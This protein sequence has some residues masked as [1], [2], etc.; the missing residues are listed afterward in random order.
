M[1]DIASD[2]Q[3]LSSEHKNITNLRELAERLKLYVTFRTFANEKLFGII[4]LNPFA[5][6]ESAREK[7]VGLIAINSRLNKNEQDAVLLHE[8]AHYFKHGKRL[9]T[10]NYLPFSAE[11]D[12]FL[13]H[14]VIDQEEL[15]FMEMEADMF[16]CAYLAQLQICG[17][18]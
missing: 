6:K 12:Q 9:R 5:L 13:D 11:P 4:S 3:K 7:Y 14:K 17:Q 10:L 15:A 2:V 18:D 16:A 1:V 8:I